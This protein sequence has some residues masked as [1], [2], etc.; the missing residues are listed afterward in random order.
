MPDN[1]ILLIFI[2]LISLIFI[3]AYGAEDA[4]DDCLKFFTTIEPA[5]EFCFVLGQSFEGAFLSNGRILTEIDI[6]Y[7]RAN[8][9][10]LLQVI[11]SIILL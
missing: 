11:N 1:L 2:F 4:K 6:M 9:E 7:S 3:C 8:Y 5:Y 10:R